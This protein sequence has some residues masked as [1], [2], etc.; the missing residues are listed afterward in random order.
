VRLRLR[1]Q[2]ERYEIALDV[3][4]ALLACAYVVIGEVNDGLFGFRATALTI[5]LEIAITAI[6]LIEYGSRLYAA[7]DRVRFVRTHILELLSL[8]STLRLLRTFQ[9]FRL[10]RLLR[11]ARLGALSF[12]IARLVRAVRKFDSAVS[13]PLFAYGILGLVALIFFGSLALFEFEKGINPQIHTFAD[14]FWLAVSIVLTVGVTSTKPISDE[15]RAVAGVLIVGGLTCISFFSSAM[16]VRLQR[17][18]RSEVIDRLERIE[19]LLVGRA[20]PDQERSPD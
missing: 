2:L 5:G 18:E 14:A 7:E 16:A 6:F 1:A 9:V 13:E 20:A 11:L 17:R 15:G 8:I 3:T 12:A 10:L 4:M 19:V